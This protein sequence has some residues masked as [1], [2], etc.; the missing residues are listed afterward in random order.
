MK[1]LRLVAVKS[2]VCSWQVMESESEPRVVEPAAHLQFP[3]L[4]IT[5]MEETDINA[6][7]KRRTQENTLCLLIN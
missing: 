5:D 6:H 1:K 2:L 7:S 3:S 4:Y